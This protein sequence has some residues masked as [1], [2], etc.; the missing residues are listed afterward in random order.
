VIVVMYEDRPNVLLGVQLAALSLAK[1]SPELPILAIVPGAPDSFL[2]WAER[3]PS[4]TVRANRD[5]VVGQGWNVKPSV[6][7]TALAEGYDEAL[8]FDTDM[9]VTGDIQARLARIDSK[10]V[11]ATEEYYWGHHQGST[12]RTSGLGMTPGRTFES[13]VNTCLLRVGK[14]HTDLVQDWYD[15]LASDEYVAAQK[16]TGQY[17]P[18]HLWSDLHVFTGLLGST[19]YADVPVVQL[20]RGAD[21]AQCYGPSGYTVRERIQSGRSLPLLVH[22]MGN[23]PWANRTPPPGSNMRVRALRAFDSVHQDL[24]PY[25]EVAREYR[26]QFEGD[27][28]WLTPATRTGAALIRL[29]PNHPAL[30]ELPLAVVD[31][32]QRRTRSVLGIGRISSK[33]PPDAQ[34]ETPADAAGPDA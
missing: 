1:H 11:V 17:R 6:L 9:I 7:Q 13:T 10:A 16:L 8:W 34:D 5:G 31:T 20:R 23:K 12:G 19:K 4:M 33:T 18:L 21:I 30:R 2:E 27:D 22:A 26:G 32:L 24:T 14:A 25:V 29:M 3:V 28:Q 15:V